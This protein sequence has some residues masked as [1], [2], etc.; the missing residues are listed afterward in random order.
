MGV[1]LRA[2]VARSEVESDVGAVPAPMP[3]ASQPDAAVIERALA[4]ALARAADAGRFDVVAMLARELEARRKPRGGL[5]ESQP[6]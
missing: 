2:S 5:G 4:C 6:E 3:V 1:V